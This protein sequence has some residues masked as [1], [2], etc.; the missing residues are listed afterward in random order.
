MLVPASSSHTG[1][2]SDSLVN[3]RLISVE[4]IGLRLSLGI[5]I[6]MVSNSCECGTLLSSVWLMILL[7]DDEKA[8]A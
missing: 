6:L 8:L 2:T 3:N 1:Q 4:P 5:S 7:P